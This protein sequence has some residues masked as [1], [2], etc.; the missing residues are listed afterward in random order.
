MSDTEEPVDA[1]AEAVEIL[2]DTVDDDGK[3]I[4]EVEVKKEVEPPAGIKRMTKKQGLVQAYME[5]EKDV[6]I[7]PLS[8]AAKLGKFNYE[9]LLIKFSE[10]PTKPLPEGAK[11]AN[12]I[13]TTRAAPKATK[14]TKATTEPTVKASGS[15]KE[16]EALRAE[17]EALKTTSKKESVAAAEPV[18]A[19]RRRVRA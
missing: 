16:V 4:P 2:E 9:Q 1:V 5:R 19:P 11:R 18:T 12:P 10:L 7:S 17:L 8:T 14:A 6:N 13:V 3:V 15:N